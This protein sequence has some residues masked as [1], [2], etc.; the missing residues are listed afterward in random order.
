MDESQLNEMNEGAHNSSRSIAQRAGDC[1]RAD[2]ARAFR[3]RWESGCAVDREARAAARER[4]SRI[5]TEHMVFKGTERRNGRKKLA[6]RCGQ[7]RRND[8]RVHGEGNGFVQREGAGRTFAGGVGKCFRIWR[9]IRCLTRKRSCAR[10]KWCW[11]KSRWDQDNPESVAHEMLVQN[12][13]SGHPL[14][15]ADPGD[16]GN[17]GRFFSREAV[18]EK[19]SRVLPCPEIYW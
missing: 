19:P 17:G 4:P 6:R 13:W 11:K 5:F 1:Y 12:F 8:G 15:A 2:A 10:S 14:G 3:F 9:C 7:H 18:V 16:A